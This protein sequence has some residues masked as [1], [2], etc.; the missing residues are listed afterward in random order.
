MIQIIT[1]DITAS[2]IYS[3]IIKMASKKKNYSGKYQ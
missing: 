2:R 3:K 1:V